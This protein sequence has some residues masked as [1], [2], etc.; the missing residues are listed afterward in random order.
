MEDELRHLARWNWLSLAE[1][2]LALGEGF[3]PPRDFHAGQARLD[4]WR[5]AGELQDE[6]TFQAR[7]KHSG[8]D[9]PLFVTVIAREPPEGVALQDVPAAHACIPTLARALAQ[10]G[11]DGAA[12]V[13][14]RLPEGALQMRPFLRALAP[15][16]AVAEQQLALTGLPSALHPSLLA[17]LGGQLHL[18]AERTF[19][20]KMN[21]ARVRGQLVGDTPE[22]RF[23]T[24]AADP[25]LLADCVRSHPMLGRLL[26]EATDRAVA[27]AAELGARWATDREELIRQGLVSSEADGLHDLGLELSDPHAG[28]RSVVCLLFESGARL[29]YKPRSLGVEAAFQ[30]VLAFVNAEGFSTPFKLARVLDRGTHGYMEFIPFAPCEDEAAVTRFF[31]RQGGFLAL[32][33]AL[34]ARDI[35]QENLIAHGECPVLVD[36][37]CLFH[38]RIERHMESHSGA[39]QALP[40]PRSVLSSS[41]LPAYHFGRDGVV[42]LGGLGGRGGLL[43]PTVP[44]WR[45]EQTDQM[46]LGE[47]RIRT[48]GSHNLPSTPESGPAEPTRY[49]EALAAG[50]E[51][52]YRLL[53]SRREAF[54]APQGPLESFRHLPVRHIF[55]GTALYAG[56]LFDATHPDFLRSGADRELAFE[57]LWDMDRTEQD[58]PSL[59]RAELG[60]LF[61]NDIPLFRTQAGSGEVRHWM[62]APVSELG[63]RPG[64]D[65]A[66]ARLRT[67]GAEDLERQLHLVRD[68]MKVMVADLAEAK[69]GAAEPAA[70]RVSGLHAREPSV[71]RASAPQTLAA[72]GPEEL[73]DAARAIADRLLTRALREDGIACWYGAMTP[74][75]EAAAGRLLFQPV[76]VDLHDGNAGIALFLGQVFRATGHGRFAEAA[77]EALRPLEQLPILHPSLAGLG[78]FQGGSSTAYAIGEL[79]RLLD[80]PSLVDIAVRI[81]ERARP[82]VDTP[83]AELDVMGGCAGTALVALRLHARTGRPSLLDV[84]RASGERLLQAYAP[85]AEQ[86]Q[87]LGGMSHGAS[88]LAWAAAEL[89]TATSDARYAEL[90]RALR[91][92]EQALF[93]PGQ[94]NWRDLRDSETVTCATAWCHGAPGIGLAG[95][96]MSQHFPTE[97]DTGQLEAA[98]AATLEYG[99]P[100]ND[101]LCH[102]ALGNAE[103]LLAGARVL[104]R[105]ELLETARRWG[106]EVLAAHRQSGTWRCGAAVPIEQPGLML[107]LAGIGHGLLR[108]ADP[109]H[110]PPVLTLGC[111]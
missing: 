78:A 36:L 34:L 91:A 39:F 83:E 111:C 80:R 68:S 69:R 53:A 97:K 104:G 85:G 81:I 20:L 66:V 87:L 1:R 47:E 58:A 6:A 28:G 88:G 54:M 94:R 48:V 57:R 15:F 35:H 93:V 67:W 56:L 107:G 70:P 10:A 11:E 96:A 60:D 98:L 49:V 75:L 50:C 99:L 43:G 5:E 23:R 95:V 26:A 79:A 18:A 44:A 2:R 7:L 62:G 84:A 59:V 73:L 32:L 38:G 46:H 86:G 45:A 103:L 17:A 14:E 61:R 77:L 102:G 41:L 63:V 74:R 27:A 21:V 8:L 33:S 82:E 12:Q 92:H 24:L 13:L 72:A 16:L 65:E 30:R 105:P 25:R 40:P 100:A 22:E 64:L 29:M 37:E 9:V 19:V 52:M 42:E 90:A 51:E 110:V 31:H 71:P 108:L 106:A 76:G 55:R 89:F 3:V 109:A 101:S 4:Y